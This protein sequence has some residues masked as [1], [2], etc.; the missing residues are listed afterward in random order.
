M[1]S[2]SHL[3]FLLKDAA[4]SPRA[5]LH[6]YFESRN[7]K[8]QECEGDIV[9]KQRRSRRIKT[10]F[11]IRSLPLRPSR[12]SGQVPVFY[13]MEIRLRRTS[14]AKACRIVPYRSRGLLFYFRGPWPH[15]HAGHDLA[16]ERET[17]TML[18]SLRMSEFVKGQ[19][20]GGRQ[21]RFINDC[22]R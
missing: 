3:L 14:A 19:T 5:K 18:A 22:R 12:L 15:S 1:N 9:R 11:P 16:F 4:Y 20:F 6:K 10:F 21:K 7:L 13:R 2:G 8:I 17:W